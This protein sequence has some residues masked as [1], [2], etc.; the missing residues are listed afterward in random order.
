MIDTQLFHEVILVMAMLI[1]MAL[2]LTAAMMMAARSGPGWLVPKTGLK[3]HR[4]RQQHGPGAPG[5]LERH[6]T[7][8]PVRPDA[9][10]PRFHC[11]RQASGPRT[12]PVLSSGV[13]RR[14]SRA[15]GA[16]CRTGRWEWRR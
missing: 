3:S 14:R 10:N 5:Q 7:P 11:V 13:V 8:D 2:A 16:S 15:G 4:H 6:E 9:V 12:E 1:V